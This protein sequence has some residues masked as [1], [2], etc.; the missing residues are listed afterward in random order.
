MS[1]QIP[2]AYERARDR[3]PFSNGT[4]GYDWMENW[5]ARCIHDGYGLGKDEPQCPLITVAYCGRTPAEWLDG[6]RDEHGRYGICDQYH[7][8][9]FRDR[10]DPGGR[11]PEPVPDPPGQTTMWPREPFEGVR[12][13]LMAPPVADPQPATVSAA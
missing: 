11:E 2:D 1:L 3:V 7:C 12:M 8:V 13:P 10:D 5:C 6:P 4:E 9:M